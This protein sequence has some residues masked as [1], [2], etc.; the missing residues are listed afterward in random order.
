MHQPDD[1]NGDVIASDIIG[2]NNTMLSLVVCF[3]HYGCRH[4]MIEVRLVFLLFRHSMAGHGNNAR[5]FKTVKYIFIT[6]LL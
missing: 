5:F 2:G 3:N 1:L 4:S 6:Y